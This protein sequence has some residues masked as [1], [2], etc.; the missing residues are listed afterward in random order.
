VNEEHDRQIGDD[1]I[2]SQDN[3]QV[4]VMGH[5]SSFLRGDNAWKD[6]HELNQK[7]IYIE[8]ADLNE[9]L[10]GLSIIL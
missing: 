6:S 8:G 4:Q 10:Q 9:K 2:V 1:E 7:V 5:K 3:T